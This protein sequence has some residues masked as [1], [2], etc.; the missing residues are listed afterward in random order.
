MK[1]VKSQITLADNEQTEIQVV[2]FDKAGRVFLMI[3][4]LENRMSEAHLF[5]VR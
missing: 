4:D 1:V 5:T 3:N 2:F